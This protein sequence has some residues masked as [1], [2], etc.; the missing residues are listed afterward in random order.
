MLADLPIHDEAW[1]VSGLQ[2]SKGAP[3]ITASIL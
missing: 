2:R 3:H 1:A